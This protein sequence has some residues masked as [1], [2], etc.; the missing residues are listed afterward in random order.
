M[1]PFEYLADNLRDADKIEWEALSGS[2]DILAAIRASAAGSTEYTIAYD[3]EGNP[4]AIYG[5]SKRIDRSAVIWCVGTDAI[6]RYPLTFLRQSKKQLRVWARDYPDI[7]AFWNIIHAGNTVH[8]K[9]IE[10]LGGELLPECPL[11]P[12]KEP[13][14]PFLLHTKDL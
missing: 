2:T 7:D 12:Q 8:L 13:F 5:L 4:A 3:P 6:V 9:W 10:W 1:D 11:G 14:V